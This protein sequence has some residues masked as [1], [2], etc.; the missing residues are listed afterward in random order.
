MSKHSGTEVKTSIPLKQ[1]NKTKLLFEFNK[2]KEK[3]SLLTVIP[4]VKFS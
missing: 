1:R 4:V 2:Y 3:F